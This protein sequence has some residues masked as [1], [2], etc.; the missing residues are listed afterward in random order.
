MNI[1]GESIHVRDNRIFD[2]FANRSNINHKGYGIVQGNHLINTQTLQ[3]PVQL[4]CGI[5]FESCRDSAAIG[6]T[7]SMCPI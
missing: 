6:N 2:V 7:I 3:L 4:G 5:L 1:T